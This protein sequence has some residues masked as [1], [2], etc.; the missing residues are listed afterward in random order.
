MLLYLTLAGFLITILIGINLKN[1]NKANIYLLFFLLIN[2]IYA[3]SHYA[4]VESKNRYLIA[5]MLVHFVPFY[6]MAGPFL[7]FYVRGLLKDD[8]RLSKLDILHF[9]PSVIML[10][11]VF[12]YLFKGIEYK[13]SYADQV[14]INP[15]NFINFDYLF[16]SPG[17][18]LLLRPLHA[19][20]YVIACMILMYKNR[21]NVF[22]RNS[23]LRL[24]SKWL[25][26]LCLLAVILYLS[27][28]LFVFVSFS[29]YDYKLAYNQASIL[30]YA[31][32]SGLIVLN[33][34][35][36]FFPNILYGLP[37]LDYQLIR[38]NSNQ[39]QTLNE[40][41]EE[42]KKITKS[43]EISDDKLKL[44]DSKIHKYLLG[45][46]FLKSNFNLS[47]MSAETDIPVHHLSYYFNE[48]MSVNFNTWKN[49]QKIEYVIE[50]M[51]NGTYENLTLDALSKQAGFGSRSSFINSFKSK[52]GLTPSE[53]LQ[54]LD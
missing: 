5:I 21:I 33:F 24:I 20:I 16:I 47:I 13:L 35:L 11:N 45:N 28:L 7:Y 50:L 6:L 25:T 15:N 26:L 36:L 53:Y 37:Q 39:Y 29:T 1:S 34:S 4:T 30:L 32:S 14:V 23:Q 9:I 3:L 42:D 40:R 46:P 44:L 49:N 54:Q 27:F 31:T 22:N 8:H 2:N 43:F 10:I 48:Y 12:P 41:E 17:V 19:L 51:R 52:T 38:T 18:N